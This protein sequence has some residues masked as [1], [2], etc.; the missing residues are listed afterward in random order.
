VQHSDFK[1]AINIFNAGCYWASSK[2]TIWS[3]E[4]FRCWKQ[5]KYSEC[6]VTLGFQGCYW[7]LRC[8]LLLGQNT[9]SILEYWSTSVE[10]KI[11]SR[12]FCS[13]VGTPEQSVARVLL[14]EPRLLALSTQLHRSSWNSCT[15]IGDVR[16]QFQNHLAVRVIGRYT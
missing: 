4:R 13:I 2:W 7:Y 10:W 9:N 3:H 16:M 12:C 1:G 14:L 8:W 5:S 11:G 6:G 15:G